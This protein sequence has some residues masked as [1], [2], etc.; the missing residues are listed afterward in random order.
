MRCYTRVIRKNLPRLN[1]M[2]RLTK[3]SE[4]AVA[5]GAV[6]RALDKEGGPTRISKSSYGFLRNEPFEPE[7]FEAHRIQGAARQ[8]P[9]DG[10]KYIKDTICWILCKVGNT[11]DQD[12]LSYADA[13]FRGLPSRP[14]RSTRFKLFTHSTQL[15]EPNLSVEKFSMCPIPAH[16]LII[17][18]ATLT[19]K[20]S[21][22]RCR[23]R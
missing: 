22:S 5:Y 6:L 1:K 18:G 20:V 23:T 21:I 11:R 7:R 2:S 16:C 10:Y 13:L 9:L 8:D 14:K 17:A 12:F 3:L 19:T 15:G 4:K